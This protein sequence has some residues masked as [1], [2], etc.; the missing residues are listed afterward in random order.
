MRHVAAHARLHPLRARLLPRTYRSSS[1]RE[2]DQEASLGA[3][4]LD[5]RA[6]EPVDQLFQRPSRRRVLARLR[7]RSRDRAVRPGLRSCRLDRRALVLPQP[8]MELLKLPHL[9]VGSPTQ[10]AGPGLPQISVCD[11]LEAARGVK[12]GGQLVGERLVVDKAVCARRHDRRFVEVASA[13]SS[14]PSIRAISAP[15][16]AARSSKFC[17]QVAAQPRSCCS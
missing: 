6:H 4:V 7:S 14:R 2:A 1:P 16:S 8:R 9:A 10:I 11:H 13:S 12:A 15:T 3:G 5:G 17:G